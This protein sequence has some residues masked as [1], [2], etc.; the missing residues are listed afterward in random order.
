MSWV[1]EWLERI[2]ERFNAHAAP[3]W[4]AEGAPPPAPPAE[5]EP[6]ERGWDDFDG[7]LDAI[8]VGRAG[9]VR[10]FGDCKAMSSISGKVQVDRAWERRSMMLAKNL[11]GYPKPVY[12]HRLVEPYLREALRRARMVVPEYEIKRLGCFAP[13][14]ERHDSSMPLSLHSWGIAVDIDSPTNAAVYPKTKLEPWSDEWLEQWPNGLPRAF[15]EAFESVGWEW[16]GRWSSYVDTMH[17]QLSWTRK[18]EPK[19]VA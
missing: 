12:V 4:I 5:H 15:V 6:L 11:P 1:G 13:R 3:P 2:R 10:C 16:G 7:G 18:R 14:H 17:F 8:P 9:V 19:G